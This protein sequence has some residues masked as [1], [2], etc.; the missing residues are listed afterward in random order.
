MELSPEIARQLR[1][2]DTT[3]K[4][5]QR[6]L[7]EHYKPALEQA[8][9]EIANLQ[10][11]N[12]A[13]PPTGGGLL[14]SIESVPGARMP[15]WYVAEKSFTVADTA[16]QFASV[17]ITPEGPFIITQVAGLYRCVDAVTAN[18]P[19]GRAL[20]L[21]AFRSFGQAVDGATAIATLNTNFTMIP[22]FSVRIEVEGS[23]RFLNNVAMPGHMI[24]PMD[25]PKYTG[26]LGWVD[27]SNRLKVFFTPEIALPCSGKAIA[28][29]VGY[30]ILNPIKLGDVLAGRYAG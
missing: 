9:R 10:R 17:E 2:M 19:N 11:T 5:F 15:Q 23:G 3:V 26:C 18:A 14:Q 4:S 13:A 29:F 22:E 28:I 24:D 16:Q 1:Q 8:Q 25:S 7:Q 12:S 27:G 21:S 20:P 6:L 30:Q